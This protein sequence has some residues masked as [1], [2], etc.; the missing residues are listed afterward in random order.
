MAVEG[1][2]NLVHNFAERQFGQGPAVQPGTTIVGAHDVGRGAPEDTFTP[3]SQNS[4]AQTTA[5]DAG[6]F[7][8]PQGSLSAAAAEFLSTHIVPETNP[9]VFA[10]Q[11]SPSAPANGGTTEAAQP[12]DSGATGGQ[13]AAGPAATA[14]VQNQIQTLNAALPALGLTNNQIQEIDRIAAQIK[15][16]N[17]TAYSNLVNQFE[18]QSEQAEQPKAAAPPTSG[19]G[20]ASEGN[21]GNGGFQVREIFTRNIGGTVAA[22][23]A[24]TGIPGS[25]VNPGVADSA[26]AQTGPVQDP[27]SNGNGQPAQVSAPQQNA[28]ARSESR[29]S[30]QP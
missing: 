2:G 21:N 13:A 6:I 25:F 30:N 16:F 17:P 28:S 8:L 18:A 3:S 15:D 12:S 19:S 10:S 20:A 27:S 9:E 11:P 7:Q 4:S 26:S 24:A 29:P 22:N 5:Q 23:N 14:E 1:I